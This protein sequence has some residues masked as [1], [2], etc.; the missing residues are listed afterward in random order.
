MLSTTARRVFFDP[1]RSISLAAESLVRKLELATPPQSLDEGLKRQ[2]RL[3]G[4]LVEGIKVG[5]IL[6]KCQSYRFVD[7][8]RH[9]PVAC[10]G[11]SLQRAVQIRLEVHGSSTGFAHAVIMTLKRQD[12]SRFVGGAGGSLPAREGR[13]DLASAANLGWRACRDSAR[14]R[15]GL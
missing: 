2:L 6:G 11:L 1:I 9:G 4:A 14:W 12:A 13:T 10:R 15:A 8:L 7:H 5:S 3:A